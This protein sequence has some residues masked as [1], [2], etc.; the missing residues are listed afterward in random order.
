MGET[1]HIPMPDRTIAAQITST[2]FYDPENTRLKI[3]SGG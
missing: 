2:V 1:V 3:A